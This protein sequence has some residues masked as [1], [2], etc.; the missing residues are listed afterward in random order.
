MTGTYEIK[1]HGLRQRISDNLASL[2]SEADQQAVLNRAFVQKRNH[3][4]HSANQ[5]QWKSSQPSSPYAQPAR[6]YIPPA[7][8]PTPSPPGGPPCKLCILNQPG[9]AHTHSIATCFQ[10]NLQEVQGVVKTQV[11]RAVAAEEDPD[12]DEY[13]YPVY[14]NNAEEENEWF[15]NSPA[16]IPVSTM[17]KTRLAKVSTCN[18]IRIQKINITESPI[19]ACSSLSRTVYLVL[20]TATASIIT[21]KM[22]QLLNLQVY[23]TGHSAVQVD[24]E[25]QLPVLGEVHTSFTRG[26]QTLHFS[27]LVVFSFSVDILAGSNFHV[28]NDVYSRMA[29]GT[30]H[31]GDHCTIK[32]TPPSLLTQDT[33]DTMSKQRLVK[34][35]TNTTLMPKDSCTSPAP[36]DTFMPEDSCTS[37]APCDR[38][39][40]TL[41]AE[42]LAVSFPVS[43]LTPAYVSAWKQIQQSCPDLKCAHSL[44]LSG[45]SL[46][47]KEK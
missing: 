32:S 38:P 46:S 23:K 37:P 14:E 8:G 36:C 13:E 6:P 20:D 11:T 17:A 26:S 15:E 45:R 25:S 47:K 19:L 28:E 5:S 3:P 12:D 22:C 42:I 16:T 44:L 10:L 34:I 18:A 24:G 29:N 43:G 21:L 41:P 40:D 2:M 27:G 1:N 33:M 35:P 31:I 7:P 4:P 9:V 39:P 30:I